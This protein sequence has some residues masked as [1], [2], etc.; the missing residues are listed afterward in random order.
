M[1][2]PFDERY[3]EVRSIWNG[4]IRRRPALVARCTGAADVLAVLR[5]ARDR[6]LEISVRGGGHAVAGHALCDGG[7]LIDLSPMTSVR[8]DPESRK[9]RAG[10]GALWSHVDRETQAFGLAV[11]GGIV[12]HT[13]IGGLTLGGGI[14]HLMRKIGLT[15]DNL[16]SCDVVTADGRLVVASADAHEDLFWGLRGGGGNF[17]IVTSFEYDVHP[18]GPTVLAGM[19]LYP[20]VQAAD[21]LSYFRDYVAQAPDEVGILGTL[22]LAPPLP[23]VPP[24]LHGKPVVAVLVCYAGD[25]EEGK[26][27]F[28]ELRSFA[29]PA[30]DTIVPKPYL[31]HQAIFDPAMPHGRG[32][33]WKSWALP[34]LTDEMINVLIRQ[35]EKITSRYSTMPIFTLGGAVARVSEDAT[36]YSN[37]NAQHNLNILGA[38]EITDP[39]PERHIAW[40][41]QTWEA[42]QPF[43]AG[44]Y[45]NFMSDEPADR[46]CAVYGPEKYSRLVAL[47]RRYDP[48]N[49][50]RHNQNITP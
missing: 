2:R 18:V 40:V 24:E 5:F 9:A 26:K 33:Y 39:D 28:E 3:E 43:A 10:G 14:G 13:G 25:I 4:A 44:A 48:E 41:R 17:G 42:L 47:K 27:E 22:R 23:A 36:A 38:W 12:T 1:L 31:A 16:R 21:V 7:V 50:F 29:T 32:Y 46:L 11:T 19:L 20:L 37:R 6:G 34:P 49:V 35:T 45:V 30:L 15:I 8:V